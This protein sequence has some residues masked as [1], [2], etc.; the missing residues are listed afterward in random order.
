MRESLT[1]LAGVLILILTAALVVPYFVDWN[2]ERGLVERQLSD[3]LG[4]PVKIRGAIDLK[5]LPTPYLRLA[6]VEVGNE[7]AKPDIK[8]DEVQL[9]I[10]LTALLRGEVDFVEAKLVRPR[11]ALAIE[12]GTLPLGPPIQHFAGPM[13]FERI[14]VEDGALDLSD[15]A[16]GR[17]YAFRNISF[18]AEASSLSGPFKAEGQVSYGGAFSPFHLATGEKHDD[19]MHIK[20]VVD[21]TSAHPSADLDADLIFAKVAAGLPSIDGQIKVAGHTDGAIIMPWLLSGNIKGDLRKAAIDTLDIRLGDDERGINLDGGGT[22]DFGKAPRASLT[23]KTQDVDLDRLLTDKGAKPPMQRLAQAAHDLVSSK[24]LFLAG[25]PLSISWSGNSAVLGGDTLTGLSASFVMTGNETSDVRFEASGPGHS[26]LALSGM[27]ETGDAAGFK[28]H[29]NASASEAARLKQWILSNLPDIEAALSQVELE[30]FNVSGEA[31]LSSVGFVGQDLTL[32]LD[33]SML[34]GTLAYTQSVGGEPGRLFADL[35]AAR[36]DLSTAPDISGL[37]AR[38]KTM[39]LSLRLDA[40]AV[41]IGNVGQGSLDTGRIAFRLEK[42]GALAKL[43]ELT[44]TDLGGANIHAQGHWDGHAG[45]FAGTLDSDKLDALAELAHRL[46]AGATSNLFLV[47]ANVLAPAHLT[48]SAQAIADANGAI[49]LD[50]F[51]LKGSAAGTDIAAT[52]KGKIGTDRQKPADLTLTAKLAAP[53][54]LSLIR[55]LGLPALPLQG[56]G[57]GTI[58]ITASGKADS[59]FASNLKAS[60]PGATLTFAGDLRADDTEPSAKG[61]LQ[62]E[63]ANLTTFLE[64]TGLAFPDPSMELAAHLKSNVDWRPGTFTLDQLAGHFADTEIAGRLA[65]DSSKNHLTGALDADHL[66]LASLVE[67]VGGSMSAP[68]GGAVWSD[69]KF[70]PAMLDPPP[71]DL[72]VTAKDFEVLPQMSGHD[73]KF[74]LAI[75][76][77]RADLA[78]ALHH[79]TM[80]LG[81]GTLAANLTFRRDGASAATSGYLKLSGYDLVLPSLRGALN[82]DLD[83]AGTGDSPVALLAG[84]AGSGTLTLSDAVLPRTDPEAM[85]RV[86]KAV[87][88]DTLSLDADEIAR[89][90]SAELEKGASHLGDV[91]F[92]AGLAAGVLRL[93]PKTETKKVALGVT[94]SLEGSVDLTHLTLNQRSTLTLTALPKNWSGAAPTIGLISTGP[95]SNSTRSIDSASFVNALAARAI[96]RDSARIEAEEFDVHEQAFFY[97]RLKSERRRVAER[98]KQAED[99]KH[100]AEERADAEKAALTNADVGNAD[101]AKALKSQTPLGILGPV[102]PLSLQPAE[103]DQTKTNET[104]TEDDKGG[105]DQSVSPV[106]L[107]A[108]R[109]STFEQDKKPISLIRRPVHRRAPSPVLQSTQ[110]ADPFAVNPF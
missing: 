12:N 38:A 88:S 56:L 102:R 24:N 15:P 32:T 10:A 71:I 47:R 58:E 100:A 33:Q 37:A 3:V 41:K 51:D 94:E 45:T 79:A 9:E 83:V 61:T 108:P 84:L 70:G 23:L 81:A 87:E 72:A 6:D 53:D 7:A 99:E 17:S 78:L 57:P 14:S 103:Q 105:A 18:G 106:P 21:E 109:P 39:D 20:L 40:Q 43:D 63:S 54:A 80:T 4:R 65:Y 97:N 77:G 13:R 27:I 67:I 8:V 42:T 19:R 91:T 89:A 73:A 96:A 86:F 62:L 22:F 98:E 46:A 49:T 93:S 64:A 75:F 50:Q 29:V 26:H 69:E 110:P 11:L 76:G 44:V 35:S 85:V 25:V 82:A 36:L 74:D 92:D 16:T 28:G 34:T 68:N 104:T 31:N 59:T 30:S 2:A 95:L 101:A 5:L 48:L 1:V 90:I 55:Q 60:L 66:A 107:P 52:I